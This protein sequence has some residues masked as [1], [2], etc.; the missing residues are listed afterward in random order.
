MHCLKMEKFEVD[1]L[2]LLENSLR[3]LIKGVF[4]H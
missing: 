4:I 1:L 3:M 2:K